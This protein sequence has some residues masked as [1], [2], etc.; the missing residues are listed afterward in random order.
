MLLNVAPGIS[1]LQNAGEKLRE[2]YR[3]NGAKGF[4]KGIN[5]SILL[6]FSGVLQMYVYEGSKLIYDKMGIPQSKFEEKNFI[7]GSI[8]KLTSVIVTYPITTV[9][10]RIQQNQYIKDRMEAKYRSSSQ[11]V[12]QL[13]REEGLRGFYKGLAA[14]MMKG[15]PQRGIYFYFYELF[16]GS[17]IKQTS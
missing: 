6:S 12:L 8:S 4:L 3:Q 10:T 1:E 11:I 13:T 14:N 15:I 16:K 7:C 17:L 9:R 5:L 2:I